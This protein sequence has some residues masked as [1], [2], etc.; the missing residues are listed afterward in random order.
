MTE[1]LV[2]EY[3]LTF[4]GQALESPNPLADDQ[5]VGGDKEEKKFCRWHLNRAQ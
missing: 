5:G 4:I 3:Y 1:F 2:T